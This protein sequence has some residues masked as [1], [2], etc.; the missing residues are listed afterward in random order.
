M[1]SDEYITS[2]QL[3][4][5]IIVSQA[6]SDPFCIIIKNIRKKSLSKEKKTKFL[7]SSLPPI[8]T[9]TFN[10][11]AIKVAMAKGQCNNIK[12]LYNESEI[13]LK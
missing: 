3:R 10:F 9:S 6:F 11:F 1:N 4:S 2:N 12:M 7:P 5:V 8:Q 13:K